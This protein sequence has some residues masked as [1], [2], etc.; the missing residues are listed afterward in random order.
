MSG[1]IHPAATALIGRGPSDAISRRGEE[2]SELVGS[3]WG[4]CGCTLGGQLAIQV[5]AAQVR[6]SALVSIVFECWC[7]GSLLM[8]AG[9]SPVSVPIP[10]GK[11]ENGGVAA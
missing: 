5:S 4:S 7:P 8:P 9:L 3:D 2:V 10:R 11:Y 1:H 6:V